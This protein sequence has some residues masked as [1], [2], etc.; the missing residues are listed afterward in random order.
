MSTYNIFSYFTYFSTK[1]IRGVHEKGILFYVGLNVFSYILCTFD[2]QRTKRFL[3][4]FADN[5]G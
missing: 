3:L 1:N 4:Q 5:A 2:A